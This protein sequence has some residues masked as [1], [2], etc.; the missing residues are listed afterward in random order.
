MKIE[1]NPEQ[2][3]KLVKHIEVFAKR[4][5]C[6]LKLGSCAQV[7]WFVIAALLALFGHMNVMV[8]G[9]VGDFLKSPMGDVLSRVVTFI[10]MGLV[11]KF[12]AS[13]SVRYITDPVR[14]ACDAMTAG[15]REKRYTVDRTTCIDVRENRSGD[16][17]S[18][19]DYFFVLEGYAKPIKQEAPCERVNKGDTVDVI[20]YDN[21]VFVI[22]AL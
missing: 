9:P 22:K 21:E 16:R 17:N 5:S 4:G 18:M 13:R 19:P 12:A 20:T 8:G 6:V 2:H 15:I 10:A 11:W 3:E 14:A 7:M 1:Y